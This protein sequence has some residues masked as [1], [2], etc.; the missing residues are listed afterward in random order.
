M[1]NMQSIVKNVDEPTGIDGSSVVERPTLD[2]LPM[3]CV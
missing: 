2:L 1:T 3:P